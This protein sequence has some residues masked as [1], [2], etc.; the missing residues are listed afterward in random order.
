MIEVR[1][2]TKRYGPVVAVDDVSFDANPGEVLGFIG[3]NGAGKTTAMRILSCYIG[4]DSGTAKVA[5]YDVFEQSLEV[6]K[7][8]GY[9]PESAP[10]YMNMGVLDSL[11]FIAQAR[12]IPKNERKKHIR[13]M[14]DLC[15]LENVVQKDIGELSK[16]FRQRVGLAQT[17]IHDPEVLILDELTSGLDPIQIIQIRN[18]IREMGK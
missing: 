3:P 18:L 7:H 4:A 11:N 6:R 15:G 8:I 14:I 16:G 13:D 17:L 5:G 2:L 9:L 10:L 1:N 12:G